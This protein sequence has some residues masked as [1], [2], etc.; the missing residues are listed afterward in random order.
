ML[1]SKQQEKFKRLY[2]KSDT[3]ENKL[4]RQKSSIFAHIIAK[5]IFCVNDLGFFNVT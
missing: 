3:L 1:I 2:Q 4:Q 5:T